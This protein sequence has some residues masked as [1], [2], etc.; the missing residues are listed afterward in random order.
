MPSGRVVAATLIAMTIVAVFIGPLASI[1]NDNTGEVEFEDSVTGSTSEYVEIP[2]IYDIT[3]NYTVELDDGTS[4]SEGTDYQLNQTDGTILVDS[5]SSTA[6]D[7]DTLVIR[8]E[9]QASGTTTTTVATLVPLF[10]GLL[11]LGTAA[12][13]MRQMM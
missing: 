13:K 1:T 4:L 12:M 10:A 11:I 2:G 5:G 6:S 7:G 9:Y 3:S 8:G